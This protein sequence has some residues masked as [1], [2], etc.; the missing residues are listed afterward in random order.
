[1]RIGTR[2]HR[3]IQQREGITACCILTSELKPEFEYKKI[4]LAL[5]K[6]I[7]AFGIDVVWKDLP[8]GV[9]GDL[10]GQE[11]I[12]DTKNDPETEVYVLLHLFGHTAQWC[13]SPELRALGYERQTFVTEDKLKEI[14]DY[15]Q[16]ASRIGL[17]LLN[18]IGRGD[19]REWLSRF[20]AADWSFLE[21]LYRE[22]RHTDM[23]VQWD[24]PVELLD[25]K[26]IPEFKPQR[27][28]HR[29]AFD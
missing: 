2:S 29:Q 11:I 8:P 1:V 6:E 15:E 23:L 26:P 13:C 16:S 22:G 25:P 3:L 17:S 4:A 21:I 27:F 28:E 7:E 12:L 5:E 9:S 14:F 18:M 19:L 24:C 10:N 20:F